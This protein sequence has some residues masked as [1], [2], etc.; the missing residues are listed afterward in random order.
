[1][2]QHTSLAC[3]GPFGR[4]YGFSH[5]C[6]TRSRTVP[7][8][9]QQF[10]NLLRCLIVKGFAQAGH[11]VQRAPGIVVVEVLSANVG[12]FV[13]HTHQLFCPGAV[14]QRK[15]TLEKVI[16]FA[17]EKP[18][19]ICDIQ[20]VYKLPVF[21]CVRQIPALVRQGH[22][23]LLPPGILIFMAQFLRHISCQERVQNP[24]RLLYFQ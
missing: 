15:F 16:P 6:G 10:A 18:Q 17:V 14:V 21:S 23:N 1:M 9:A 20:R 12:N 24:K 3:F 7:C 13:A 11:S 22:Q 5:C 19:T 2:A 4:S 8:F